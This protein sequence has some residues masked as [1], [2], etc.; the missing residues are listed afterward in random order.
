LENTSTTA[1]IAPGD[2]FTT[3]HESIAEL[4][5]LT[6]CKT[7]ISDAAAEFQGFRYEEVKSDAKR[8]M[9]GTARVEPFSFYANEVKARTGFRDV[10]F[11]LAFVVLACNGDLDVMTHTV[12]NLTWFEEWVLY[13]ERVWVRTVTGLTSAQERY[14]FNNNLTLASI[15]KSK[16]A[17]L[18]RARNRWPLFASKLEDLSL[19]RDRWSK[20][21]NEGMRVIF[22]DNT[23]IELHKPSEGLQQSL[24]YSAYYG[25]NVAKGDIFLQLCG[26]FGTHELFPGHM[27]DSAYLT[28]TDI[29]VLQR[30]FQEADGGT[31]FTDILDKG[32]RVV[33]AQACLGSWEVLSELYF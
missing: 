8:G 22:W 4:I 19:R 5:D 23:G 13:F 33:G 6:Q 26:W 3:V 9:E 32:Y 7:S 24:T 31:P 27:S 14:R 2:D 21:Y 18:L 28:E 25:G 10:G 17:L 11:L 1:E 15:M 30:K 12:T 29:L 20:K 16:E